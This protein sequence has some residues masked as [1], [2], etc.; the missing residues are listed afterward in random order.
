MNM[1]ILTA[2]KNITLA[3]V[4]LVNEPRG[5]TYNQYRNK[6]L[7]KPAQQQQ[8]IDTAKMVADRHLAL[9]TLG[10]LSWRLSPHQ[11]VINAQGSHLAYLTETDLVTCSTLPGKPGEAAAPHLNWHRLIYRET[12]AESVL[13]CHPP[14]TLTLAN[15]AKLPLQEIAP[16]IGAVIGGVNLI[17][18]SDLTEANLAEAVQQNHVI[19]APQLGALVWGDSM[20]N[21]LVR[22]DALEFVCHLT[23]IAYQTGLMPALSTKNQ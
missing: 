19:L 11:L 12:P 6:I 1:S 21:V 16:E 18:S 9:G 17:K 3:I 2:Y 14:Y 13:F 15:A 5:Y 10:E 8:F 4:N 23:T 22:A 7:L 20:V